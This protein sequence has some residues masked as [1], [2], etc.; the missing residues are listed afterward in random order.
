MLS[1]IPGLEAVVKPETEKAHTEF[2]F[3]FEGEEIA[4]RMKKPDDEG[5][6]KRKG[7]TGQ[8]SRRIWGTGI[9]LTIPQPHTSTEPSP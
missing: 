3:S 7:S 6:V 1:H 2:H 4:I 9:S 5:A 8:A